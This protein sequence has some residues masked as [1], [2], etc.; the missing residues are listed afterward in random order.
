[1]SC[2]DSWVFAKT[3]GPGCDMYEDIAC[4]LEGRMYNQ[5]TS[6]R[7]LYEDSL[8]RAHAQ[9][10]ANPGVDLFVVYN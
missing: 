7:L 6:R 5:V 10:L 1:M 3:F 8:A 9:A 4:E 2:H